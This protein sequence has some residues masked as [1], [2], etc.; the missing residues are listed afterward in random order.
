MHSW[1]FSVSAMEFLE[2]RR[3]EGKGETSKFQPGRNTDTEK[4]LDSSIGFASI[5]F[6]SSYELLFIY[7]L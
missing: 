3:V 4:V 1:P 7:Q 6:R 5:C 2:D